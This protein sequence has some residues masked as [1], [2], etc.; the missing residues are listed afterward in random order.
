MPNN[1]HEGWRGF[2]ID[3]IERKVRKS[4][5]E[6]SPDIFMINAG[7]NDCLQCFKIEEAGKRLGDMLDYL[8]LACP[9]STVLLSTLIVNADEEVNSEVMRFNE[10]CRVLAE[11]L[12]IEKRKVVLVD[13]YTSKGPDVRGL[14]DGVHPGDESYNKMSRLW[15]RGIREAMQK[16]FI[17]ESM[18]RI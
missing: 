14:V 4:V 6:H 1:E 10:Q 18:Y 16:G 17:N 11:K 3:E 5:Q 8:W 2:R 12:A 15:F 9:Q 7:S 13:M